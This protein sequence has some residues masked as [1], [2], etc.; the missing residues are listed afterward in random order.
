[1]KKSVVI[2]IVISI[3]FVLIALLLVAVLLIYPL[4]KDYIVLTTDEDDL[5]KDIPEENIV[6]DIADMPNE[7]SKEPTKEQVKENVQEPT[8][9]SF[10][11]SEDNIFEGEG[12]QL[13]YSNPWKEV[14]T[15]TGI[16]ALKYGEENT[17]LIPIATTSL[18]EVI[19]EYDFYEKECQKYILDELFNVWSQSMSKESLV[20]K[21]GLFGDSFTKGSNGQYY[22]N[23]EIKD[24]NDELKGG[25]YIIVF[26]EKDLIITMYSIAQNKM[27]METELNCW[28]TACLHIEAADK[29]NY[30]EQEH[31]DMKYD[32]ENYIAE[33]LEENSAWNRYAKHR[34]GNLGK[35]PDLEGGWRVLAD[36][37]SY[38]KFEDDKFWWYKSV[39]DLD[40]NYW[41]GTT[42]IYTGKEGFRRANINAD[43]LDEIISKSKG[44]LTEK[45][46][47]TV[48]CT[49]TKMI[50]NDMDKSNE[51]I[52]K[53]IEWTYVWIVCNHGKE[54]IEGQMINME[55]AT[56]LYYVKVED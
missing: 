17:Y 38:W 50:E 36:T 49:P 15:A 43:K 23:F 41:Y 21:R 32:D 10:D 18:N 30:D 48:I 11:N 14:T 34:E 55:T 22:A 16:K 39:Y 52:T 31:S 45:D 56:P 51:K 25:S 46:I 40:D 3:I 4:V 7:S 27:S 5:L 26:P 13:E 44:S 1:M 35:I 42:E 54:G 33:H 20:V 9:E 37:E 8:K 29:L 19:Q 2:G 53:Q 6:N 12:Y 47:Y 28:Q 24:L